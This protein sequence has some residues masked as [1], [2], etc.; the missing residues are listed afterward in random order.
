M[1]GRIDEFGHFGPACY[2]FVYQKDGRTNKH[3][4]VL[5]FLTKHLVHKLDMPWVNG[6]MNKTVAHW[7]NASES[8]YVL[9]TERQIYYATIV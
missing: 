3:D 8:Y 4:W 6:Q 5:A 2:A 9:H 1:A 7:K